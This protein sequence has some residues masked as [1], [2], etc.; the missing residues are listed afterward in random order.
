[1]R[2]WVRIEPGAYAIAGCA[3]TWE[4]RVMGRVLGAGPNSAAAGRSAAR[5]WRV[6]PDYTG[7]PEVVVLH[8][9]NRR[10]SRQAVCL[11]LRDVRRVDGIPVTAPSLTLVDLAGVVVPEQLET[12]LDEF[13]GL[14][15][16]SVRAVQTYVADRNLGHRRGAGVLRE[17]LIDRTEGIPQKELERRFLRLIR[18][19]RLPKPV[20]QKPSGRLKIDFAYPE[21]MIAIEVDGWNSHRTP[22][23]LDYDTA[24]Q[25]RLAHW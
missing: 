22:K 3:V 14:G 5:L 20:R 23:D 2:R 4:M 12:A 7:N 16:V 9:T 1:M 15:L 18:D 11:G 6:L 13:L 17:L 24:R 8:G 25:N 19:Y 21:L 10:A